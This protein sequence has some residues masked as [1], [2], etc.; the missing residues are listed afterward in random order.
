MIHDIDDKQQKQVISSEDEEDSTKVIDALGEKIAVAQ[1][2]HQPKPRSG[3][4]SDSAGIGM[5]FRM[6]VEMMASVFV[7]VFLGHQ[8]DKW[9][10][11]SP[12]F[13]LILFFLGIV[14]GFW[15]IIRVAQNFEKKIAL[16][17][18]QAKQ[19][20]MKAGTGKKS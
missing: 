20:A 5:G 2:R 3:A 14:T 18:E 17:K 10:D 15:N 4:L 7:G 1:A 9:L 16:E 13:L 8:L 19:E 6:A 11:S 12:L